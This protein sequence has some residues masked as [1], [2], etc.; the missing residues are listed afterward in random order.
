M[1]MIKKCLLLGLF[2]LG[3]LPAAAQSVVY[4]QTSSNG[5]RTLIC[6]GINLGVVNNMDV[7][8]AL[9]GFDYDGTVLYS[10]AVVVGSGNS[11]TIPAGGKC[12]LTLSNGKQY[13]L[14]TVA[15]GTAVLQNMDVYMD[16]V[17]QSYQRF[18]YYNIKKSVLKKLKKGVASIEFRMQP[19]NYSVTF[20]ADVLGSLLL[21]SR[22][23]IDAMFDN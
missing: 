19:N 18:A 10:L 9:A 21:N 17:Y 4:D 23:V 3:M 22:E 8:V 13:E 5:V 11:T 2:L 15:G 20:D 14:E 16:G 7:N 12:V 6:E 1:R